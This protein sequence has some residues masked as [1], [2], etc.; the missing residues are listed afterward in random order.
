MFINILN[1]LHTVIKLVKWS[2]YFIIIS[3]KYFLFLV[4]FLFWDV[5]IVIRC[6]RHQV[7]FCSTYSY[8]THGRTSIIILTFCVFCSSHKTF[9]NND[10]F[11]EWLNGR[12]SKSSLIESLRIYDYHL[13]WGCR[14]RRCCQ[15]ENFY[16]FWLK[17][18]KQRSTEN[19]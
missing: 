7:A 19:K 3:S 18:N 16:Q 10:V 5:K 17:M 12:Y 8:H 9:L 13:K 2:V 6:F 1:W 14:R 11:R 15:L 4:R